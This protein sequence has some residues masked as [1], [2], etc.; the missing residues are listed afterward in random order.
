MNDS[1][2]SDL[3]TPLRVPA[4]LP[5]ARMVVLDEEPLNA[6]AL[7]DFLRSQG[8]ENVSILTGSD[9]TL[10]SLRE[11]LPD[12]VL[13]ELSMGKPTA[14]EVLAWMRGDRALRHVPV[15]ALAETTGA[16]TRLSALQGGANDVLTKPVEP[17]ELGARLNN[18]LKIKAYSDRLAHTDAL[19]G[20]PNRDSASQ[21]LEWAL[22]HAKR[23]DVVGAVLKVGLDRIRQVND[24]LGPTMGSELLRSVAKRLQNCL[25]D[26]DLVARYNDGGSAVLAR[27][28]G[29][30]FTVLLPIVERA[31]DTALVAQRIIDMM[32]RPFAIGG[33]DIVVTCRVG[34]AVFPTDGQDKDTVLRHAAVA[35]RHGITGDAARAN[36][37]HFYSRELNSRSVQRLGLERELRMALEQDQ[38]VLHYQPK[39]N[40]HTGRVHG[41]EALVRWKHPARGLMRPDEF[42]PVAEESGLIGLLGNWVLRQALRQTASWHQQG[43]MLEQVAVNVSS[44]QFQRSGLADEVCDALLDAGMSGEHLCLELTETAIMESGTSVEVTLNALKSLGVRLSLDDFGTGY[45]S[46]SYLHRLPLDEL[47]I[48][49]SFLA[50]CTEGAAAG[51]VTAAIIAMGHRLGLSVVAEGVET[52]E[53]LAFIRNEGCNTYQGYLFARPLPAEE[54]AQL[55]QAQEDQG[56]LPMA[57]ER[58]AADSAP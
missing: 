8:Y 39:V 16:T 10:E 41:A 53:Q 7:E 56:T 18:T 4:A 14:L 58:H 31:E 43:L 45:S 23:Y 15:I 1:L 51:A 3:D 34:I 26:T 6:M 40:V 19:T 11:A 28:E 24:S 32:T 49:R 20:L 27:G 2:F 46:L 17:A 29:D 21:R 44:L 35:M 42:I 52:A 22:K 54:F 30:E 12:L 57:L 5:K 13:V 38:L 25:R 33:Y 37:L 9:I 48:D 50:A 36:S 55:M 47:K